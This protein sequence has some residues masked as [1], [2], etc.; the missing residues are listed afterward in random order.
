MKVNKSIYTNKTVKAL[1]SKTNWNKAMWEV[2]AMC[3]ICKYVDTLMS[4]LEWD[5]ERQMARQ[6]LDTTPTQIVCVNN[7]WRWQSRRVV[8]RFGTVPVKLNQ[9]PDVTGVQVCECA[10]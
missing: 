10:L 9:H 8:S 4:G 2:T 6:P 1:I 7:S 3:R 5:H